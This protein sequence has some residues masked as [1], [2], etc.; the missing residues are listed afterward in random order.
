MRRG[1]TQMT[2]KPSPL[3][4]RGFFE[5]S[6]R[7]LRRT[8]GTESDAIGNI[9]PD[10]VAHPPI[11]YI[12]RHILFRIPLGFAPFHRGCSPVYDAPSG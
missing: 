2:V 8:Y 4:N 5:A 11:I 6:H 9:D 10:G 1:Q 3:N 12:S 7:K